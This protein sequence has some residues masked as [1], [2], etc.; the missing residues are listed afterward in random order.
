MAE[1]R[2]YATGKRKTS[3]ARVWLKPGEGNIT[4]NR[5]T[6]DEYFGRETSKMVIRQP[7]ELTDNMGKFDIMVN[8]CGGGPSGQAGAIKHGIT[9]ALLEADPELRGVLKKA[10][11]ITRDS[12]AKERKKYGRKGARARFQFSKR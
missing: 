6:L 2:F 7:L 3:I 11:F 8:V 9:K 10:G 5:R 1:Q 4:V 12:R